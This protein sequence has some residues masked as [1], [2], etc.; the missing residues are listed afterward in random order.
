MKPKSLVSV[1]STVE[2]DEKVKSLAP[3]SV[4]AVVKLE[5]SGSK[6]VFRISFSSTG[7]SPHKWEIHWFADQDDG[8]DELIYM[9]E[10]KVSGSGQFEASS[11]ELDAGRLYRFKVNAL[12]WGN[13]AQGHN[14]TGNVTYKKIT[15]DL[16]GVEK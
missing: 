7:P 15:V 14:V 6:Y 11:P 5:R 12:V 16:R 4:D 8:R 13:D 10:L 9:G 2:G 1:D 3:L